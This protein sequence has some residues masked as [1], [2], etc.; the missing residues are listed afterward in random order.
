MKPGVHGSEPVTGALTYCLVI[1]EGGVWGNFLWGDQGRV[2]CRIVATTVIILQPR[3]DKTHQMSGGY[4]ADPAPEPSNPPVQAAE[5]KDPKT[6][7]G[8]KSNPH[9]PD[10][11][12][13]SGKGDRK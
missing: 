12:H 1:D 9:Y 11:G 3:G 4:G 13:S 7:P 8:L 5:P 6:H 2:L 10:R